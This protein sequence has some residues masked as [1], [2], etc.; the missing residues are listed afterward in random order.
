MYFID[1]ILDK[2]RICKQMSQFFYFNIKVREI[3][4]NMNTHTFLSFWFISK[5]T[6]NRCKLDW[7]IQGVKQSF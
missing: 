2:I 4:M 5:Q 7:T 3:A 1:K 6:Y